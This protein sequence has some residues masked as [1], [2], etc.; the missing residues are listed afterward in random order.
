MMAWQVSGE[1]IEYDGSLPCV[2]AAVPVITSLLQI[3]SGRRQIGLLDEA[4]DRK[5]VAR[6]GRGLDISIPGFG[7]QRF[8]AY[9][10]QIPL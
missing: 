9:R 1:S 10:R 6:S 4:V 7:I 2:N 5:C 3:A 8:Y